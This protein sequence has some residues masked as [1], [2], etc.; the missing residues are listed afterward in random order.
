MMTPDNRPLPVAAPGTNGKRASSRRGLVA[1]VVAALGLAALPVV[2][3]IGQSSGSGHSSSDSG[4]SG[5]SSGH[6]GSGSDKESDAGHGSEKAKGRSPDERARRH[7][8]R[9]GRTLGGGEGGH[10]PGKTGGHGKGDEDDDAVS[11]LV[12]DALTDGTVGG[13]TGAEHFTHGSPGYWG[14][15]GKV[16][17]R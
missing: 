10:T 13:S 12:P 11:S 14:V 15:D 16:L 7:R 4:H 9:T 17:R 6:S 1:G 2:P 8:Q 3:A 5:G